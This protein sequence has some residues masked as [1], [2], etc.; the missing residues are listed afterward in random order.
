[1]V[2]K[3][4][5]RNVFDA[6]LERKID[7]CANYEMI[8]EYEEKFNSF[9]GSGVTNNLLGLFEYSENFHEIIVHFNWRLISDDPDDNKFI[10]AYLAAN[11]DILVSNDS[12]IAA[13]KNNQFPPLKIMSIQE[14]SIFLRAYH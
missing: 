11:A 13:L 3:S 4:A 1:L 2:K 9:W 12:S 8:L 6:F 7:F 14:F 10:D 5:Y